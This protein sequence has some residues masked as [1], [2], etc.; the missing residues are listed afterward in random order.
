MRAMEGTDYES[1]ERHR[2]RAAMEGTGSHLVGVLVVHAVLESHQFV[3]QGGA[4]GVDVLV[5]NLRAIPA[6]HTASPRVTHSIT[7]RHTQPPQ[8]S[9]TATSGVTS[10]KHLRGQSNTSGVSQSNTSGVS[11]LPQG[12]VSQSPQGSVSQPPQG[13][14]SHLRGQS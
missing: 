7:P 2:L 10:V 13:S 6:Q 8:G 4:A 3:Q 1:Y 9:H 14:V 5:Q 12:S 11:Q